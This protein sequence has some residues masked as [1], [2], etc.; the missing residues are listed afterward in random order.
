MK[1]IV[2]IIRPFQFQAVKNHLLKVGINGLTMTHVRGYGSQLGQ[3]HAANTQS[4]LGFQPKI[5][6]ELA[7]PAQMADSIVE[8]IIKGGQTGKVGDGKIFIY[9]LSQSQKIRTQEMGTYSL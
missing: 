4:Y 1:M 3:G 7:V 9:S 5:K 8:A 2:A 6:I